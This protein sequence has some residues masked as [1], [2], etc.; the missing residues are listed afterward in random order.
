MARS[1]EFEGKTT[2]EALDAAV[3]ET[4]LALSDLNF[5][6]VNPGGGGIFGLSFRKAKIK[7]FLE[8]NETESGGTRPSEKAGRRPSKKEKPSPPPK[9][10]KKPV[11]GLAEEQLQ[12]AA[13]KPKEETRPRKSAARSAW[14]Q[15]SREADL[16]AKKRKKLSVEDILQ[17][18][19]PKDRID[20]DLRKAPD[21]GPTKQT[22]PQARSQQKGPVPKQKPA[23]A[24]AQVTQTPPPGA[25]QEHLDLAQETLR[26]ILSFWMPEAGLEK[27]WRED[28]IYLNIK[29][30]G[31]GLLIGRK[32]QT[33][34]ALQFIVSKIVDKK[35]GRHLRLMIDTE[36]YR[37]RR[38][39]ALEKSAFQL[40]DQVLR[41]GKN[42]MTPPLN[43]H[44]R[45][46]VHLAL[47][48]DGRFKTKSKGEG[49]YKRVVISLKD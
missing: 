44:E 29:G 40:A 5:E 34:D 28:K 10:A 15:P 47:Q 13:Q 1:K 18:A 7:V 41:S 45:R 2:Q 46:I 31:S 14:A 9:K 35:V 27:G 38:E 24:P 32:G 11:E 20:L 6:I 4:G 3:A 30:D 48:G 25:E 22:R 49:T 17:P 33:L 16:P 36:E 42:Q 19:V 43:P 23:Q 37:G 39:R 8:N 12:E 26:E 21:Q